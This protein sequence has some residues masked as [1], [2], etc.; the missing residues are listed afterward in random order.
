[1]TIDPLQVEYVRYD[2]LLKGAEG[3]TLIHTNTDSEL[4]HVKIS[5]SLP[6]Q[7][8]FYPTLENPPNELFYMRK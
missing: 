2:L 8:K 5:Y 3:L 1:M 6:L 7:L 4:Q